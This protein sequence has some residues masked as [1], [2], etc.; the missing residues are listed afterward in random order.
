MRWWWRFTCCTISKMFLLIGYQRRCMYQIYQ[1]CASIIS[2][3]QCMSCCILQFYTPW[4]HPFY[5]MHIGWI[6]DWYD[7]CWIV[8][9]ELI[10]FG[11]IQIDPNR[12]GDSNL[13]IF[14]PNFFN[15]KIIFAF[16]IFENIFASKVFTFIF[17][18]SMP[19]RAPVG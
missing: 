9:N 7:V 17:H 18:C 11:K 10:Q 4:Q 1:K 6:I 19:Q 15:L 12:F 16:R 13:Q 5:C 14:L 2:H 8:W 3:R